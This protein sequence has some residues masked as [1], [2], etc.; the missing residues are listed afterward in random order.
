MAKR[1]RSAQKQAR[2]SIRRRLNNRQARSALK[3]ALKKID[4]ATKKDELAKLLPEVQSLI[5]RTARKRIIHRK[6]ADRLKS[7][8]HRAVAEAK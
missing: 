3:E 1:T 8:I 4:S 6:N 5:D 7:R 2:K